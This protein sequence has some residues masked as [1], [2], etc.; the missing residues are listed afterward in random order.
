MLM[1][2]NDEP[3]A[4]LVLPPITE[5][6][7]DKIT[8]FRCHKRPLPMPA[9][10]IAERDAFFTQLREELPGMLA[11]L[12][13]W[14]IPEALREERCGV[15]AFHHPAI[16]HGLHELSPEGQLLGLIDTAEFAGSLPL[17]WSGTAAMLRG[18][19][20]EA[21]QTSRDAQKLLQHAPTAGTYLG[22]LEGGRVERLPM[23]NGIQHWRIFPSG[24]VE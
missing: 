9:H 6:I 8:L 2:L 5:D 23:R 7:G 14:E 11:W 4:L 24:P 12:E 3:E 10:T 16:L 20:T 17:P 18:I 1:A 13:T 19:L 22:R 21:T 15:K